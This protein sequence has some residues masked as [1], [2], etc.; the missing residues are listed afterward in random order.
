MRVAK[1]VPGETV[2]I[3]GAAGA[4][5]STAAQIA[6]LKGCRTIGIAGGPAKCA[7]TDPVDSNVAARAT[8]RKDFMSPPISR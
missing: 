6:K 8:V 1:I 5:G 7:Q 4:T 3:S 2:L